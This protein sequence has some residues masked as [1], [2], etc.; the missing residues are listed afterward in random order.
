MLRVSRSSQT[1]VLTAVL[2]FAVIHPASAAVDNAN[3]LNNVINLYRTASAH[4]AGVIQDAATRLFWSLAAISIVWTFGT[5]A[6]RKADIGEFFAEFIRFIVFTGFY[7][8]LLTN[9]PPSGITRRC[10]AMRTRVWP[11]STLLEYW[12]T[13]RVPFGMRR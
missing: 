11:N 7:L 3:I 9:G 8:W 6:L 10:Q 2:V 1:A 5:M 4:W 13:M 12:P